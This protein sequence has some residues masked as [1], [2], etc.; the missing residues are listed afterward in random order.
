M[1]TSKYNPYIKEHTVYKNGQKCATM[2]NYSLILDSNGL[3]TIDEV[4][5]ILDLFEMCKLG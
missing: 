4:C 2:K 5:Q 1:F 3:F